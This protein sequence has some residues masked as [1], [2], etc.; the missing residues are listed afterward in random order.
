MT[1]Q[2]RRSTAADNDL[3]D[4]WVS[5]AKDNPTAADATLAALLAAEEVLAEVPQMG[6]S[7]PELPGQ[8]RSWSVSPYVIFYRPMPGGV[9]VVRI[10]HGAR[11]LGE[12]LGDV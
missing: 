3:T 9:F 6:R 4:I 7:R 5:I 11:D 1:G 10:L 12:T 8:V 2:V